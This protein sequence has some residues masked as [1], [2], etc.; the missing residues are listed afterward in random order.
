VAAP[1]FNKVNGPLFL[2]LILLMGIGPLMAWRHTSTEAL[3]RQ[4]TWPS[5]TAVIVAG[6]MFFF[7][8][9]VY[10]IAGM[11]V[12]AFATATIVQEYIR[13]VLARRTHNNEAIPVAMSQLI[14]RNGRR[15]GGYIVHLGMVMIGVA[16]IGNEFFQ[17]TTNITLPRGEGA[18]LGGYELIYTGL[19]STREANRTEI[20][21][22]IL[23][24]DAANGNQLGSILP[25][26]NIYDKTPDMPTSEVGLRMT[27]VEDV[28]V[29]LNGWSDQGSAATFT[30]YVN[31][32]T[33]WMWLGGVIL[34]L[35]V[36]IAI[37]PHPSQR[38][39]TNPQSTYA[40]ASSTA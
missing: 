14:R 28:Y 32:L 37:W 26:R 36:L 31:P 3:R 11:A 13:G 38:L 24:F 12:C 18:T 4:F 2:A 30:I 6:L 27:L 16:V 15:Y 21:A 34:A 19:E 23:I 40:S 9:N 35:G 1:F 29:V 20:G 25:R 39:Q 8:R 5:L 17:Q 33:I 10:P 7:S 22:R